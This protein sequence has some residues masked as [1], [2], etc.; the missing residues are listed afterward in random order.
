VGLVKLTLRQKVAGSAAALA[1][2]AGAG[3]AY[4]I[5]SGR[6]GNGRE[7]FLNDVAKRLNVS[8]QELRTAFRGA[9]A[10][11]LAADVKA[12]R[13]TQA[14]ADRIEKEAQEHGGLPF[15]PPP[16]PGGPGHP[17]A[18][19]PPPFAGPPGGPPGG[20][21]HGPHGPFGAGLD[22]AA[23]YL[24]L[25]PAQLRNRLM[26]GKSLAQVATQQK[27]SVDGLKSA[28]EA[29]VKKKLDQAVSGKRLTQAQEDHILSELRGRLDDLVNR[30][31]GERPP[32]PPWH[33]RRPHW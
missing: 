2:L 31:P 4:A 6:D 21:P 11:R 32:R 23:T 28:I 8:P 19:G 33:H 29:A 16:G 1:L 26:S 22:A 18:F 17:P 9:L 3:G 12:G 24:G 20:P 10:D 30:R 25:T 7:A 13:I 5:T 27:K 15:P 14:E